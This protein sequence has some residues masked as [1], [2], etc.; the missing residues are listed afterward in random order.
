[1][2]ASSSRAPLVG[3]EDTIAAIAT[4]PGRGAL[5]LLRLSGKSARAVA[6]RVLPSWDL[7]D[8]QPTLVELWDPATGEQIDRVMATFFQAP[9]SHTGDDLVE[10][11]VE[12]GV[13][14]PALAIHALQI[15]PRE[16]RT[17]RTWAIPSFGDRG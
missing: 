11:T 3:E 17:G 13:L 5:A 8:R 10:V 16:K 4:A 15:P 14:V 6:K 12:G 1:M 7:I 9:R 2:I